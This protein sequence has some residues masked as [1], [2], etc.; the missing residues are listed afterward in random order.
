MLDGHASDNQSASAVGLGLSDPIA[1]AFKPQICSCGFVM[2]IERLAGWR[3]VYCPAPTG[4][5]RFDEWVR[6]E[7]T[8]PLSRAIAARSARRAG[9]KEA[10]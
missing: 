8:A 7:G 10:A 1:R 6:I 4:N 2:V 9:F 5:H 3:H